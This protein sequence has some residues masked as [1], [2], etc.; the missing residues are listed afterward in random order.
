MVTQSTNKYRITPTQVIHSS[1]SQI[2]KVGNIGFIANFVFSHITSFILYLHQL[3][4]VNVKLE[5]KVC[6]RITFHGYKFY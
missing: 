2:H 3:M 6:V 1:F 5:I 4:L